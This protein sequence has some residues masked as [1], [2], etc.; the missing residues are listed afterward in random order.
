MVA[1][2]RYE[3]RI[4]RLLEAQPSPAWTVRALARRGSLSYSMLRGLMTLE[5]RGFVVIRR[6]STLR[7]CRPKVSWKISDRWRTSE[8]GALV[9]RAI[10]AYAWAAVIARRYGIPFG[11]IKKALATLRAQVGAE[12]F[13]KLVYRAESPAG[14]APQYERLVVN[15]LGLD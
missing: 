2:D 13:A 6:S 10:A 9:K 1:R 5:E 14:L 15:D 12:R 3:A 11:D 8:T 7:S 4:D